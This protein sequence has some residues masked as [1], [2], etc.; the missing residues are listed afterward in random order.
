MSTIVSGFNAAA[1]QYLHYAHIQKYCANSLAR[2]LPKSKDCRILEL[3]AG[4]GVFTN[5][6]ERWG[7]NVCATDA[8][9][10]MCKLGLNNNPAVI[11]KQ[12]DANLP[13]KGPWDLICSS[14]MLQWL[15]EPG[16]TLH[17]WKTVLAPHGRVLCSLFVEGTLREW[18][19][20]SGISA[21]LVWHSHE[22]WIESLLNSGLSIVR[23]E[24]ETKVLYYNSALDALRTIHKLGASS[25][26]KLGAGHLRRLMKTYE[27][28]YNSSD[29]VAATWVIF[30]FEAVVSS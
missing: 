26:P 8:S 19:S 14:S 22:F 6:L 23:C 29:G 5:Y 18:A 16:Q 9:E 10:A 27:K 4:P 1:E 7:K 3:G 20:V 13:E 15:D 11:W 25:S 21:P 30:R 17:N 12:M 2:W 24:S 28:Q